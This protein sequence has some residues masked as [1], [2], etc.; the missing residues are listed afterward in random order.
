MNKV[1]DRKQQLQGKNLTLPQLHR[2]SSDTTGKTVAILNPKLFD[3]SYLAA[4]ANL[5]ERSEKMQTNIVNANEMFFDV[6]VIGAGVHEQ[7]FQN[8]LRSEN[9][10]L[11]VLTIE[12]GEI[13]C[14]TFSAA[15]DRVNSNSSVRM[16]DQDVQAIPS[17]GNINTFLG[18]LQLDDVTADGLGPLGNFAKVATINR[19]LSNNDILFA[20]EVVTVTARGR[21]N[22][23]NNNNNINVN[24][25]EPLKRTKQYEVQ[26]RRRGTT[27]NTITIYCPVVVD[28][29]G[30]GVPKF[31]PINYG[32]QRIQLQP[33]F[34][35]NF[36]QIL[37]LK[38]FQ[39]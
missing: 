29:R 16:A 33:I 39:K 32:N 26:I 21:N 4:L 24:L 2:K 35:N 1:Q 10:K 34:D 13:P 18:L 8:T 30:I 11:R 14:E 3:F 20:G 36:M 6:I 12:R 9:S 22:N 15:S 23:S 38:R 7:I 27:R 5:K 37:L 19:S 25:R 28:A 31:P 17:V